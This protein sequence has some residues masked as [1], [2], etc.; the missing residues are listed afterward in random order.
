M[1]RAFK[2]H[3]LNAA[4]SLIFS[5]LIAAQCHLA[6][7]SDVLPLS[8]SRGCSGA[9]DKGYLLV[10]GAS[11]LFPGRKRTISLEGGR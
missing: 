6:F 10:R 11:V 3:R 9:V 5:P 1:M 2:F 7:V 4:K 8:G